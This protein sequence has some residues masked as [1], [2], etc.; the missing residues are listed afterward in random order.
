[1]MIEERVIEQ[2]WPVIIFVQAQPTNVHLPEIDNLL[3][4]VLTKPNI[5]HRR[6]KIFL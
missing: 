2:H 3:S 6:G 1:M 4:I 5:P